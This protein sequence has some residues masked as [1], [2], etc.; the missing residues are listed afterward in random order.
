M[1]RNPED[2]L[3][4]KLNEKSSKFFKFFTVILILMTILVLVFWYS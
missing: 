3:K 1:E 2:F 4:R